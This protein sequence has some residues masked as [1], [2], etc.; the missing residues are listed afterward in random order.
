ML[1]GSVTAGHMSIA[2]GQLAVRD[3]ETGAHEITAAQP[4]RAFVFG[5]LPIR[6]PVCCRGPFVMNTDADVEP[7][8][9]LCEPAADLSL[10]V[11][12]GSLLF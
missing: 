1:D 2:S 4:S 7:A 9:L 10:I 12:G 5:G 11:P 3:P 6:E 8:A